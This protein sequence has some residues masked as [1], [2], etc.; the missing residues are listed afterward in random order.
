MIEDR[1]EV[2]GAPSPYEAL[3]TVGV[4]PWT[5]HAEMQDVSFELL[6]RGLMNPHT[7]QAWNDLRDPRQRLLLDLFLYDIDDTE[8]A[9]GAGDAAA[10][11]ADGGPAAPAEP[12]APVEPPPP[13][14]ARLLD[15]LI[16]FGE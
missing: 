9:H 16:R 4:T 2:P 14:A 8:G 15:E 1:S 10:G 3:A 5:T 7:Q 12:A 13:W 11:A 6:A